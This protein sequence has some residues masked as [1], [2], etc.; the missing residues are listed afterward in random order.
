MKHARIATSDIEHEAIAERVIDLLAVAPELQEL[1]ARKLL[2]DRMGRFAAALSRWGSKT[3]LTASPESPPEIF[4]HIVESLAPLW[5]IDKEREHAPYRFDEMCR[6]MDI[7]SGAGFPGLVLAAA[8][9]AH[10][11]LIEARRK[12]ASFLTVAAAEIGLDNVTVR[13][14]RAEAGGAAERYDI[15][16]SRAVRVSRETLDLAASALRHGGCALLYLS[17]EQASH[18]DVLEHR[19]LSIERTCRYEIARGRDRVARALLVMRAK[20]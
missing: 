1:P 20:T 16:T 7:G 17:A 9:R 15:V 5:A 10:F 4:F 3:N 2:L 13:W 14:N 19:R 11:S 6:V 12:R 18:L 8:T